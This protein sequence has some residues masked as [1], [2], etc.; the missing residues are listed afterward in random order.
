A[1]G[2]AGHNNSEITDSFWDLQTSGL[3]TSDG[4]NGKT[5]AQMQSAHT[6]LEAGWDLTDENANGTE[7]IWR[8]CE[9]M[10]YPRLTWQIQAGDFVCPDGITGGDFLFFTERWLDENCDMGND[11]C[12]G[13]D[14]DFSGAVDA[15]DLA[16]FL[17]IWLARL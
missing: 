8:I 13:A 14:L 17:D 4:G 2:L 7:D 9:A 6:F 10:N 5:T 3:T 1:G 15:D 12:R 16:I 11:Y